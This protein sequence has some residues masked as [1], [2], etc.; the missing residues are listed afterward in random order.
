MQIDVDR[1]LELLND[2]FLSQSIV[3][4][5][6]QLYQVLEIYAGIDSSSI[7]TEFRR[8][9]L[10]AG[11]QIACVRSGIATDEGFVRVIKALRTIAQ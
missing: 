3:L 1:F 2:D 8:S 11:I 10:M 5:P 6:S 7:S 9:K 4:E